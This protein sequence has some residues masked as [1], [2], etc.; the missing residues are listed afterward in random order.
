MPRFKLTLEYHG[1]GFVGWQR[2]A[3]GTS[4]QGCVE[5][6]LRCLEADAPGIQGAGRTD[7][8]VHATGQVAHCDLAKDWAPFRLGEALNYHLKPHP[9]SI[10]N[11][12]PVDDDFNARFGALRREYLYR[13]RCRRAPLTVEKGLA[14]RLNDALDVD[15]MQH[16]ADRLVGRHD[17]TT[18]RSVHCQAQS[19]IKTLDRFDVTGVGD[20]VRFELTARSFLHNQVRSFVGTLAQVGLGRW[21]PQDVRTALKACDRSACG[22]VAPPDGLYLTH[23]VYSGDPDPISDKPFR[24]TER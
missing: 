21:S 10:L 9:I 2:Q 24:L 12:V 1:G 17:F 18:F 7:A 22:P 4:V 3:K 19:P 15:A 23:V 13:I 20:E 5:A 8:G 11:V 16:A 6:A 14:W